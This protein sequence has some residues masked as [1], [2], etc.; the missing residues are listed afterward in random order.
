[1][2]KLMKTRVSCFLVG[3]VKLQDFCEVGKKKRTMK[4]KKIGKVL[5]CQ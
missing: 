5:V 1:M 4:P 3:K 2:E